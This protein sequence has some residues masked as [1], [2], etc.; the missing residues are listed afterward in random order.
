MQ[1]KTPTPG[2][3]TYATHQGHTL[4]QTQEPAKTICNVYGNTTDQKETNAALIAAAPD[5]A[6][7][8][9]LVADTYEAEQVRGNFP[10]GRTWH[11]IDHTTGQA[12]RAA[13][14]KAEGRA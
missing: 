3:W 5:L 7:V 10:E 8:C 1:T 9:R 4:V 14:A 2:P 11:T 6:F 12:A 13:I